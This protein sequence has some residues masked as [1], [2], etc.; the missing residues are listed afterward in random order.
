MW[1][2]F[3]TSTAA[4]GTIAAAL[5]RSDDRPEAER[6]ALLLVGVLVIALM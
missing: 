4:I 5:I 1:A 3:G 2:G 6:L